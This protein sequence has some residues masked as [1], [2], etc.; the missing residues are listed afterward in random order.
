MSY[1][2]INFKIWQLLKN[3]SVHIVFGLTERGNL[4]GNLADSVKAVIGPH[5]VLPVRTPLLTPFLS[6]DVEGSVLMSFF[7][8]DLIGRVLNDLLIVL[9]DVD[10]D[11]KDKMIF[12]HC[13][14]DCNHFINHLLNLM[15]LILK[16]NEDIDILYKWL[17]KNPLSQWWHIFKDSATVCE[18]E[19]CER[20]W[21]LWCWLQWKKVL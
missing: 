5:R 11:V 10:N 18:L 7:D 3:G 8:A 16:L 20:D 2:N 1:Q 21:W 15:D 19:Y 6:N 4:H 12:S 14:K 13:Y 9:I 17:L